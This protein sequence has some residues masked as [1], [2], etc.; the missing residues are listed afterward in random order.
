MARLMF[1]CGMELSRAFCTARRSR[2]FESGLA[3]PSLAAM[4]ISRASLVKTL[5]RSASAFPFFR[6]MLCHLECPDIWLPSQTGVVEYWSIGVEEYWD[7]DGSDSGVPTTPLLHYSI[8]PLLHDSRF[9]ILRS[10]GCEVDPLR[11]ERQVVDPGAGS[12]VDGGGKRGERGH[13]RRLADSLHAERA[14]LAGHLHVDVLR[15]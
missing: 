11:R 15:H 3:P 6:R 1:S 10:P 4:I 14:M 7:P 9:A 5:P 2:R 8:T 12:V 13:N